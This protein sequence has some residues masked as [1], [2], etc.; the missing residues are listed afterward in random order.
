[1]MLR[2][3]FALLAGLVAIADPARADVAA[4]AAA[5]QRGD[6]PA[7]VA[8]WR[9]P[10]EEGN[11]V[12]QYNLGQAYKLGR[13]VAV[14]LR[15]A[16]DWFGRAAHQGHQPSEGNYG[17]LLFQAG[18]RADAMPW[19]EKAAARGEPASQYVLATA[20][21]NGEHVT[22][23]WVRAYALMVRAADAGI[24][25]AAMSLEQMDKFIPLDQRQQGL[26]LAA[27]L[28]GG[29]A[30]IASAATPAAKPVAAADPAS[31]W[32]VQLGAFGDEDRARKLWAT[33]SDDVAALAAL[34]P[35]YPRAGA[36]V[37]LQ[38]GPLAS[39]ADAEAACRAAAAA[40]NACFAIR[41]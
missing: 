17:L 11:P 30:A 31:G 36:V 14:D 26:V 8:A 28:G 25:Q 34:Q 35:Y 24:G 38:A 21:F 9:A 37:R 41:P 3:G 22:K 15:A 20:L 39:K 13:G 16:E 5:W 23:D 12:A 2:I 4:G 29:T 18:K 6:Y 33:L 27:R 7:A 40:G 10:A 32:R 19:I 1:M